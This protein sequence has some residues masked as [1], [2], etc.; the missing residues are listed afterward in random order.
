MIRHFR[1]NHIPQG[2]VGWQ[3]R[4]AMVFQESPEISNG[5]EARHLG[6]SQIHFPCKGKCMKARVP[7]LARII[8]CIF[9]SSFCNTFHHLSTGILAFRGVKR[10]AH[11]S[12]HHCWHT[13]RAEATWSYS[14]GA[15]SMTG[16]EQTSPTLA[17]K[18][19]LR[20]QSG[21]DSHSQHGYV[22]VSM[23]YHYI[24]VII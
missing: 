4:L 5:M 10:S 21:D 7:T 16:S 17:R 24:D 2:G 14:L 6:G 3:P 15:R 1:E 11:P 20:Q 12:I 9:R 18:P 13:H 22:T 8:F 23:Y 19:A